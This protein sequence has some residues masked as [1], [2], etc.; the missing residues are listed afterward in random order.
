MTKEVH[1]KMDFKNDD[2][3]PNLHFR[4]DKII[5]A[6]LFPIPPKKFIWKGGLFIFRPI[7]KHLQIHDVAF[8]QRFASFLLALIANGMPCRP[9]C[10]KRTKP[11]GASMVHGRIASFLVTSS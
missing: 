11:F 1:T 4:F 9:P 3:G 6:S 10:R 5:V 2:F 8:R 7:L